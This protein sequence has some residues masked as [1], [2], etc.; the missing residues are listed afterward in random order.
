MEDKEESKAGRRKGSKNIDWSKT[1]PLV[2]KLLDS[3]PFKDICEYVD[4]PL[5]TVSAWLGR[6]HPELMHRVMGRPKLLDEN[7]QK[8]I[9]KLRQ[10]GVPIR[11]IANTYNV[12]VHT[13]YRLVKKQN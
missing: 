6:E 11:A 4:L 1:G 2:L 13:I 3:L 9:Y 12:S 8:E 10:N 7:Q 5:T